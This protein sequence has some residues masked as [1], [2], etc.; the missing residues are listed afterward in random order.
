MD[1]LDR[2]C[3]SPAFVALQRRIVNTIDAG[4]DSGRSMRSSSQPT[5][6]SGSSPASHSGSGTRT[7]SSHSPCSASAASHP[8]S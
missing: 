4:L 7:P 3:R 5:P 6:R 1:R 8:N 2:R